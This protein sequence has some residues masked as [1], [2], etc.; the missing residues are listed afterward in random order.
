MNEIEYAILNNKLNCN[1]ER[2]RAG[3]DEAGRGPVI[4]PMV[5]A[6]VEA[7]ERDFPI[8]Q[9]LGIRDS[10]KLTPSKRNEIYHEIM[11]LK[12]R[13]LIAKVPPRII[14]EWVLGGAGLNALEAYLISQLINK[15]NVCSD[16][17]FLDA[18]S[19]AKSFKNYLVKYGVNGKKLVADVHAEEKWIVVAAAS[20]IAKV[21]RDREID[22]IRNMV[23]FDI[24]SGY[25]SD[26]KTQEVLEIMI[27]EYPQF[28][29]KSWK[30][31]RKIIEKN[32]NVSL[33]NLLRRG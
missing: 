1:C 24:G 21:T 9:K 11:K 12:N 14:D 30:T 5:M 6:L 29:R 8:L 7:D 20:I 27:R 23:G 22:K 32:K 10:K 33:S 15:Y 31:A 4:G 18:P 26:P 19:N 16:I 3:V 25:P 13:I 17:I 28:V 2:L